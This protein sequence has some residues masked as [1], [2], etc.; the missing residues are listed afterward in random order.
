VRTS[1]TG[2]VLGFFIVG[3]GSS[4]EAP[5]PGVDAAGG[6]GAD[7]GAD[8]AGG[9]GVDGGADAAAA[10]VTYQDVKPLFVKKCTPCHLPGGIGA[11]FHTLAD[12]YASAQMPATAC[13]GKKIGECTIVLVK[14]GYMPFD[15]KCTGDPA[16]DT[17]ND[18]CLTAADQKLLEDWIAGG[19]REK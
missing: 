3:C 6:G 11:P 7:G 12:S 17:A 5:P 19:L 9:G 1:L 14:S 18:A 8:A 13:A 16:K 4:T 10:V 15:R 2:L